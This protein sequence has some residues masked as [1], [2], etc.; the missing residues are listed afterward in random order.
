MTQW[1]LRIYTHLNVEK[2]Q[3]KLSVN[4]KR[5]P[6]EQGAHRERS[7]QDWKLPWRVGWGGGSVTVKAEDVAGQT[8]DY[9]RC[10]TSPPHRRRH[11]VHR[12]AGCTGWGSGGGRWPLPG[13]REAGLRSGAQQ[14]GWGDGGVPF[15]GAVVLGRACREQTGW[16]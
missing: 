12:G 2:I 10:P 16:A 9:R 3:Q 6:P 7:P 13:R 14:S 15:A 1:Y 4:G 5:W 11:S 8:A